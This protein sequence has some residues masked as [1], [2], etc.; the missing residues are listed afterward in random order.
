MPP[1]RVN[2]L[3]LSLFPQSTLDTTGEQVSISKQSLFFLS[4]M[5]PTT[6]GKE[7]EEDKS[8]PSQQHTEQS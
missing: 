7:E 3:S 6:A 8:T 4:L 2:T 1:M 5:A